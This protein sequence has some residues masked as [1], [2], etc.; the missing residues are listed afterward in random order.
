MIELEKLYEMAEACFLP[1]KQ[2]WK[3]FACEFSEIF[4]AKMALYK[5]A[6]SAENFDLISSKEIISTTSPLM[7][8]QYF[9]DKIYLNSDLLKDPEIPFEPIRRTDGSTDEEW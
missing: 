3:K 4:D 8:K 6:I 1:G 7:M 5:P 2:D 9:K